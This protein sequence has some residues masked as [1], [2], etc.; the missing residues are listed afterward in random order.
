MHGDWTAV[1]LD[2]LDDRAM[3]SDGSLRLL[4]DVQYD[5]HEGMWS[6]CNGAL[7]VTPGF[8]ASHGAISA[9]H[10]F[11]P[12]A[13]QRF[14]LVER[15]LTDQTAALS[16]V[17]LRNLGAPID[18]IDTL[19]RVQSGHI[20]AR[21]HDLGRFCI[22]TSPYYAPLRWD[23]HSLR[24]LGFTSLC[25][26]PIVLGGDQG[27]GRADAAGADI[28]DV[29]T[30]RHE[31]RQRGVGEYPSSTDAPWAYAYRLTYIDDMGQESPPSA[32]AFASGTN[33]ADITGKRMVRISVPA[34]PASARAVRIWRSLNLYGAFEPIESV[35]TYLLAEFSVGY[36]FVWLDHTPDGE[37]GN[38]LDENRLGTIP[39]GAR[40]YALWAGRMWAGGMSEDGSRLRSSWPGYVGQWPANLWWTIGSA[41]TGP[42]VALHPT[43]RGLLVGKSG[44]L[45]LVKQTSAED[46]QVHT[47]VEGL[48]VVAPGSIVTVP[49]M[50]I[51]FLSEQGPMMLVGS[52]DDDRITEVVPLDKG[53]KRMWESYLPDQAAIAVYD[54]L[55]RE[56]W[57]ATNA[58]GDSKR[59]QGL[60]YHCE[61]RTWSERTGWRVGAF[62]FYKGS[63]WVASAEDG[64]ND[65]FAGVFVVTAASRVVPGGASITGR[66]DTIALEGVDLWAPSAVEVVGLSMG[67]VAIDIAMREGRSQPFRRVSDGT[68]YQQQVDFDV[69]VW[70]TAKW[71]DNSGSTYW[72]DY[73]PS[74]MRVSVHS[75]NAYSRSFRLSGAVFGL[76]ALMLDVRP[77]TLVA[78]PVERKP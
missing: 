64:I 52:L 42:I 49:D 43:P 25:P 32:L 40:T 59:E 45:Y 10:W 75:N 65:D 36:G 13:N 37:L 11:Q 44:G 56:I 28:A 57:V 16:W 78:R 39:Q 63:L 66:L 34:L 2:R 31:T 72:A 58:G 5:Q 27:F 48:G 19:R 15:R 60:V 18:L 23:G 12:R 73:D 26:P 1:R 9:M 24:S 62:E 77:E 29:F 14:L 33:T 4:R 30:R 55:R 21:F 53:A 3:P 6:V 70:G 76:Y 54:P 35:S 74:K 71:D 68:R 8:L 7:T 47:I 41:A 38:L 51:F 69:P 17:D 46:F 50:G 22:I 67:Q 61:P 20:G